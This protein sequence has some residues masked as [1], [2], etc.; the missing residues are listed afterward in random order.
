MDLSSLLSIG[1]QV[2]DVSATGSSG[3][4][5]EAELFQSAT[6]DLVQLSP[7]GRRGSDNTSRDCAVAI[8]EMASIQ[9]F[10]VSGFKG[11]PARDS[12]CVWV[13]GEVG[14]G[15]GREQCG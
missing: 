9:A 13:S 14:R 10:Y 8:M 3:G 12:A 1:Q 4:A 6:C 11:D 7:D 2:V 5:D 15:R